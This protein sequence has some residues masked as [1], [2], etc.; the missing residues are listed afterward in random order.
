[1]ILHTST[2]PRTRAEN[3][4]P[5]QGRLE[6]QKGLPS[7]EKMK[8]FAINVRNL[9]GHDIRM[10]FGAMSPNLWMATVGC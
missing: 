4:D 6:H 9:M 1:L 8:V 2:N 5:K 3:I 10:V 7:L